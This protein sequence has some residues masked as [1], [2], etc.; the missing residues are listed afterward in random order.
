MYLYDR[1]TINAKTSQFIGVPFLN[2]T[3]NPQQADI[4]PLGFRG[5]AVAIPKPSG[6]Y[7]IVVIGASTTFGIGLTVEEAWP[8][9][10][11]RILRE[12]YGYQKVEVVNLGV[13]G[14]YSLN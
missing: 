6:V 7:R 8:F 11:Q 10:L 2:Y 13:P 5:A 3:L 9:Q 4:N 12:Q 1:A 14:Y